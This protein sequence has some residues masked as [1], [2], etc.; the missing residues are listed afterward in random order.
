M[1]TIPVVDLMGG[2]VVRGVAGRRHEYRPVESRLVASPLPEKVAAALVALRLGEIYVADLDAIAGQPPDRSAYRAMASA[3]ARLWVDAGL[4]E[5]ARARELCDEASALG[6]A[7]IIAGL[8]SLPDPESLTDLLSIVGAER[9]VFSLDLNE[10]RPL[11]HCR[12]WS[13]LPPD[14]IAAAAWRLGI[15]QMIVLD[16]AAVGVSRG[17]STL[18]LCR[19]LHAEFPGLE[20]T[21]GG[22]VR[23][24]DDLDR[25]A[26]AGCAAAL[27]ASALHDGRLAPADCPGREG[28]N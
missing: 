25:L 3:G 8:E 16:L 1:R 19:R 13:Q 15:R 24:R 12:R 9:L 4:A 21:S 26:A 28:P 6:I 5:P 10:G 23:S 14:E 18:E 20:L 7:R 2:Q 22:G 27:V 11:G 17:V